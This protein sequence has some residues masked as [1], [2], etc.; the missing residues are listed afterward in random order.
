MKVEAILDMCRDDLKVQVVAE[1]VE[2]EE[3]YTFL[4]ERGCA[5]AQG[6]FFSP[7]LSYTACLDLLSKWDR[8]EDLS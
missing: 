7:A 1:G 6:Y 2:T 8:G 5:M 4:K 3:Q